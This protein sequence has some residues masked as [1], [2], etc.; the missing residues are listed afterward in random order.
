[1][2][3]LKAIK[4]PNIQSITIDFN[5]SM[6]RLKAQKGADSVRVGIFQFQHGTIKRELG[7]SLG[8]LYRYFNSSM[9][10]LKGWKEFNLKCQGL[11]NFNSSMV[12]LKGRAGIS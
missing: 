7:I 11:L 1:M 8:V 2:V 12:R 9:V 5:S 4:P 10:R 3:R 6:V